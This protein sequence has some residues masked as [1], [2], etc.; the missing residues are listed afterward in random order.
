MFLFFAFSS[1]LPAGA[2]SYSKATKYFT[3]R[4]RP[5]HHFLD[6]GLTATLIESLY[7][8]QTTA[9]PFSAYIN[10]RKERWGRIKLPVI[11]SLQYEKLFNK[12]NSRIHTLIGLR[13]PVSH[14]LSLFHAGLMAGVSFPA[15]LSFKDPALEFRLLFTHII[16]PKAGAHRLYFQWG[17]KASWKK[18]F[19]P[20]LIIQLG[21]D[22]HL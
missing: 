5:L 8:L 9:Y 10:Y 4:E 15:E 7:P 19:Q 16:G 20:G 22:S 21:L 1:P 14:D 2:D 18:R 12:Q 13:Y 6:I 11:L 3:E 17:A